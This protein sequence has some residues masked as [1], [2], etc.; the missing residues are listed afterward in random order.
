MVTVGLMNS[1]FRP[2][3]RPELS[4]SSE[5]INIKQVLNSSDTSNYGTKTTACSQLKVMGEQ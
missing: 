4:H 3:P 1:A 2:Y 5:G